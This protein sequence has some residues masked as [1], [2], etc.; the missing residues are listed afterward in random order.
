VLASQVA[1]VFYLLDPQLTPPKKKT[2]HVVVSGKQHI[3]GVDGV[4]GVEEYNNYAEMQ[5]FT[6]FPKKISAME[7][8]LPKDI[9]P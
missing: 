8:N 5:L 1:Q 6:D 3:I 4:D 7:K 9:L 2:K